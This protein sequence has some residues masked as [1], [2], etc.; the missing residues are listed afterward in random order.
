MDTEALISHEDTERFVRGAL[1]AIS[2]A[3]LN[4]NPFQEVS[5]AQ[6]ENCLKI[7]EDKA[8]EKKLSLANKDVIQSDLKYIY[9]SGQAFLKFGEL[10]GFLGNNVEISLSSLSE[11]SENSEEKK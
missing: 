8:R 4:F 2:G 6:A 1:S 11:G 9:R 3:P 7:L 5:F 10:L